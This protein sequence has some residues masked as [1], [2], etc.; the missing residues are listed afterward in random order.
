MFVNICS[1]GLK[2]QKTIR[3]AVCQGLISKRKWFAAIGLFKQLLN[4]FYSIHAASVHIVSFD[5]STVLI[6]IKLMSE[7]CKKI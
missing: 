2:E 6:S 4:G 7:I 1:R 3:A 5:L